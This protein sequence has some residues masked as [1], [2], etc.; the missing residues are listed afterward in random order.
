[1]ICNMACFA[2]IKIDSDFVGLLN[3]ISLAGAFWSWGYRSNPEAFRERAKEL[4]RIWFRE[5]H[6]WELGGENGS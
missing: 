2:G 3:K 4:R 1:M 5:T 6:I